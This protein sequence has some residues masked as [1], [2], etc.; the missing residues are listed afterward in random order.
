MT[1]TELKS[2]FPYFGGKRKVAAEVWRRF[3]VVDNYVEPFFGSGAVL[4]AREGILSTETVNDADGLI[5]NFWRALRADP[6]AVADHANWPVNETDLHARHAWLVE[7]KESLQARM[8]GDADFFDAK[9][10]G[11]WVWGMSCWIGSGFCSGNGPWKI[12]VKPEQ[13]N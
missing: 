1:L 11:W 5:S 7:K 12:T 2:P 6:D 13:I 3:G 9:V 4:L 10:A 8:E